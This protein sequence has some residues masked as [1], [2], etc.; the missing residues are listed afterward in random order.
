MDGFRKDHAASW[1]FT[2]DPI[3][4]VASCFEAADRFARL[5][6]ASSSS[7]IAAVPAIGSEAVAGG[8]ELRAGIEHFIL[9]VAGA[10]FRADRVPR[11]L[12]EFDLAFRVERRRALRLADDRL[13]RPD[14]PS[15]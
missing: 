4:H 12:E 11:G 2:L 3:G 14:W 1:I 15:P 13:E 9:R 8:H 10:E 5:K 7:T 6:L